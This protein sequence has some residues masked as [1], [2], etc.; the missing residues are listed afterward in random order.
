MPDTAR[1][2]KSDDSCPA[3]SLVDGEGDARAV[4]WPGVGSKLRS[5]ARIRLGAAAQTKAMSHPMEAVY[6]VIGGEGQVI[7]AAAA[8]GQPLIPGS[9]AHIEPGTTYS[10]VAGD[11]G[12]EVIGGPCPPDPALYGALA[13][14]AAGG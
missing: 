11:G 12:M 13:V 2:L 3:L 1:V 10:F 14:P 8:A 7:D 6:Y 5:M 4:A 9:M